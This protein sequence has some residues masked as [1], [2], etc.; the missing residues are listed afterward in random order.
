MIVAA[1]EINTET[2]AERGVG[3][4]LKPL[5]DGT[6][7]EEVDGLARRV[8]HAGVTVVEV[9]VEIVGVEGDVLE[10]KD[11]TRLV[12]G[13]LLLLGKNGGRDD[14]ASG[15]LV[16]VEDAGGRNDAALRGLHI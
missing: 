3:L 13:V 14:V 2:V 6:G 7:L 4:R 10:L 9:D 11:G 1:V 5:R 8:E 12:G 16:V 15:S